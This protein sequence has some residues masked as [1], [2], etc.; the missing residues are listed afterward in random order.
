MKNFELTLIICS[1]KLEEKNKQAIGIDEGS[2]IHIKETKI[3]KM[4]RLFIKNPEIQVE[5]ELDELNYANRAVEAARDFK[6]FLE[7]TYATFRKVENDLYVNLVTTNLS[8]KFKEIVDKNKALVLMSGTLH[9]EQVLRDIFGLKDFVV[10]EAETFSQGSIDIVRTGKEFD[11]RYSTF[12]SGKKSRKDYL[13]ALS[14]CMSKAK[15]PVLVHVNAFEDLPSDFEKQDLEI[16]NLMSKDSLRGAQS[17]DKEGRMISL[18]KSK[19]LCLAP[20]AQEV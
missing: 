19:I 5:I 17:E 18:F 15:K 8:K 3:D 4:L 16:F 10:I 14:A 20:S 9:S 11:C 7:D 6:E 12:S 13:I 1:N 2:V